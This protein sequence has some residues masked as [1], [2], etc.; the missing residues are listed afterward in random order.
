M[1][2][3]A[4]FVGAYD[5]LVDAE[6]TAYMYGATAAFDVVVSAD[7]FIY[8]GALD[9]V[10]AATANALCRTGLVIF[11][12]EHAVDSAKDVGFQLQSSGRYRHNQNYIERMLI[13]AGFNV[14]RIVSDILRYDQ[15]KPVTGLVVAAR[16]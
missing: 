2:E 4:R 6:L 8:F 16:K 11:T 15:G 9:N 14:R 1:L 5:E 13:Q 10:L 3:K 12:V 7:T